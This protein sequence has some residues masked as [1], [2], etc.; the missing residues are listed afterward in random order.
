MTLQNETL[1]MQPAKT[2][3]VLSGLAGAGKS[4]AARALEDLGFFVVDNL[5]PQLIE[6]LVNLSD[7]AGGALTRMAF[8]VDAR[9][10]GFLKE[11]PPTWDRLRRAGHNL[12]LV[13]LD[14]SDD[15]LVRRFKET[16]RRHPQEDGH[17]VLEAIHRERALL[18]DISMSA[19]AIID[20][21]DLSVHD[22]KRLIVERF[23]DARPHHAVVTLMS[24]GFK[25][26]LPHE[27][28]LCLDV[29]F[30][31]NPFFV[32]ALRPLTGLDEAV[33]SYVLAQPDS[34]AFLQKIEDLAVFLVP[35]FEHEGKAYVTLAIGCTGGRHRS[36]AI[37]NALA[38]LL[39]A[40]GLDIRTT[41]RDVERRA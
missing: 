21:R 30:L 5:P 13:F 24:F 19:D 34:A 17:G 12:T 4:T 37:V 3:L 23:G 11:F 18:A 28:D 8:V 1:P 26:G 40:R 31:P 10:A 38:T 16:R 20:T 33:S 35:R 6:T 29:R 25:Y 22:L 7:S 2:L 39:R 15:I 36:P 27:L 9:E 14:C 32:E 41:H